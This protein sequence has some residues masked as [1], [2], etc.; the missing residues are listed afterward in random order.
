MRRKS[1]SVLAAAAASPLTNTSAVGP[2]RYALSAPASAASTARSVSVFLTTRKRVSVSRSLRAQLGG[3]GHGRAAVVHGV[4]GLRLAELGGHLVDDRGFLVS[5]QTA[6]P[7][8][9][10]R[11]SAPE[12]CGGSGSARVYAA[13]SASTRSRV[14]AGS[15]LMP[16]P[17][18][19]AMTIVRRYLPLAADGLARMSSSM[20]AW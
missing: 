17:W 13:A 5:V 9:V 10:L 7:V 2:S 18:V 1:D 12:V 14:R 16:G 8:P 20:T 15:I 3:L 11:A 4:H 19:E 6:P